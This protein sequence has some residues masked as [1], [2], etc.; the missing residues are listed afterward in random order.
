MFLICQQELQRWQ[1]SRAQAFARMLDGLAI[2]KHAF[3]KKSAGVWQ[4][5]AADMADKDDGQSSSA[6]PSG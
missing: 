6:G 3:Y 4:A 1:H 2:V 5:V